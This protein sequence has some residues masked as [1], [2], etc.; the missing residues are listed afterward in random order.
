MGVIFMGVVGLDIISKRGERRKYLPLEMRMKMYE[1]VVELRRRELSYSQIQK[2]LY[3]KYGKQISLSSIGYWVNERHYPL[4]KIN[5]FN[6][7]PS[8]ELAYIIG[9]ILSDGYKY[10]YNKGGSYRLQLDA[11]DRDFVEEFK[12]KLTKVLQR[13]KPYKLQWDEKKGVWRV[14]GYS[15]QLFE[16]LNRPLK[17]LKPYIEYNKDC[18][19]AFLRA[20][21]DAEGSVFVK[22]R[23]KR[24]QRKVRLY[25]SNKELLN[26]TKYLL[27]RYFN[28]NVTIRVDRKEGSV[29]LFPNNK[30]SKTTKDS[31]CLYIHANSLL[32]FYNYI[33]F[34]IKRKQ[35][36]LI[37]AIK[38]FN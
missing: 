29:K 13:K 18:I 16:F 8:P 26:Y 28:I 22:I 17:E 20:L 36:L 2:I 15:I 35:R 23:E 24:R 9:V 32:N 33:G 34:S 12:E 3:E 11:K 21:F 27:E 4:G 14:E 30:I 19:S 31:Y 25:N 5:K 38:C 10:L 7:E 6:G 37:K 1:D